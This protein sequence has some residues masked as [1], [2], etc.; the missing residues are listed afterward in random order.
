M[1]ASLTSLATSSMLTSS[2]ECYDRM[3]EAALSTIYGFFLFFALFL[4]GEGEE[5]AANDDDSA[6]AAAAS[7]S[8]APAAAA[9]AKADG[10]SDAAKRAA[11]VKA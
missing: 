4:E 3:G 1:A 2:I 5:A 7:E 6:D 8:A 9:P 11:V 10:D